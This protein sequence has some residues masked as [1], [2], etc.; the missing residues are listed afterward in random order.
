MISIGKPIQK[1]GYEESNQTDGADE[2]FVFEHLPLYAKYLLANKIVEFSVEQLRL[3]R[4]LKIPFFKNFEALAEDE[5]IE[6]GIQ[7]NK[8]LLGLFA[9][10]N[11]REFVDQSLRTWPTDEIPLIARDQLIP[12][13][14]TMISFIRRKLFRDF[15]PFYTSD[16]GTTL[17]VMEEIDRLFTELDTVGLKNMFK[18]R[19]DL[20]N[21][22]QALA[23][24][25]SWVWDSKTNGMTWS[26]ELFRIY[27]LE[28]QTGLVPDM[29]SFHHPDDRQMIKDQMERTR[30][31]FQP[32]DFYYRI[33][34]KDKTEK[35]LHAKGQANKDEN[36]QLHTLSGTLQDVTTQKLYEIEIN[37]KQNFIQKIADLTPSIIAAYNIHSGDYI[38]INQAFKTILGYDPGE[39]I[40]KGIRFFISIIHPDDLQILAEQNAYTLEYA[41]RPEQVN[42][43]EIIV[44]FLYR[45]RHK[46]GHYI[47]FQTF[48]T[49]FSRNKD[50]Q[51]EDVLNISVDI[52]DQVETSN[53]LK[54]KNEELRRNEER[55]HKMIDEIEDYAILLLSKEGIIE[56]WNKGAQKIKGYKEEEIV[57]KHFSIFYTPA[58]QK[59]HLADQLIE[60]ARNNGKAAHEGWRVRKDGTKFWG[61][62]VIT[63][64]HDE[65]AE[66][67]GFSKVTRDLTDKKEA[68]DKLNE[69][70]HNL[71]EKN[72]ELEQT[73]KEL[74]SF[75]Y[76]AGHD[77]QEPLRKV[78]TFTNLI[79][80]K[81]RDRFSEST[82][83]Y[84]NRII[85]ATDRMQGLIEALLNYSRTNSENI[86]FEDADL[87]ELLQEVKINLAELLEEKHAIIEAT[88][89]PRIRVIPSQF[90]QLFSNIIENALKYS[91]EG[92][93][94]HIKILA[95]MVSSK[96]ILPDSPSPELYKISFIDNGIGFEQQYADKIFELFQRLHGKTEYS[97][98]GIGLA[99]C[100]KI[101]QNHRGAIVAT[102]EPGQGARFDI[103]IPT[104]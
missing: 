10:N 8:I 11:A 95:E 5:L 37:S 100:K 52:T 79:L 61:Y 4:K 30:E 71:Q 57:G 17:Q 78:K 60:K 6:R 56:N 83:D 102:G 75:S 94:P 46:N 63:S 16:A 20:S 44:E 33:L 85:N 26:D 64:L 15:L 19:Q 96:E 101:I 35:F 48:G 58:D 80:S 59:N 54:E 76:I 49:I 23:H 3:L 67:I 92:T 87:N 88:R 21:Q 70:A 66:V 50:N 97:G 103:F 22:S 53:L 1:A 82:R 77:L 84:F 9:Q 65:N 39:V 72:T 51:V 32:L 31:T 24:I 86:V 62:V 89:L 74:E 28:P 38:F 68:E 41:N 13:D 36:G 99:I 25:G 104:N 47:W 90:Q 40:E 27:G 42:N 14:I 69:Y 7:D 45:M 29:S 91:K 12:E 2:R 73:N 43:N 34:L 18:L 93:S 98:T 81:E 55:H